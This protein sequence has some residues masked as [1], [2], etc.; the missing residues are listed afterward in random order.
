MRPDYLVYRKATQVAGIGLLLQLAITLSLLIFGLVFTDTP[1]VFAS[2]YTAAGLLVWIS[3]IVVF[4]QH[5][6]ERLEALEDD[7]AGRADVTES[8][9]ASEAGETNVAARRLKLMHKWAMPIVS[10]ALGLIAAYLAWWMLSFFKATRL[11]DESATDFLL[12][13]HRGWAIA[14]CLSAALVSFIFSR[15][16]AGMA[17]IP[18]WQNLRGGASYMAGNAI[19]TL[20]LAI[21]I[22]FRFFDNDA[23]IETIARALPY[24]LFVIALEIA[25]NFV[26]NLYRPRIAGEV[27]RPAFD[28]R[29][30]SR[31]ATPDSIIRSFNEAVNYQFGFDIA[32]SWGYQ[33]LLRSVGWLLLIGVAALVLLNT[34]VIV[35]PHQQG[36]RLRAGEIVGGR[37]YESGILWK[38]PW[39]FETAELYDVGRVRQISLTG[40]QLQIPEVSIWTNDL[41][42]DV[43]LE[44]F[45]VSS[46]RVTAAGMSGFA[47]LMEMVSDVAAPAVERVDGASAADGAAVDEAPLPAEAVDPFSTGLALV[48]AE[49]VMQYRIRDENSG[50]IEYLNFAPDTVQR[51]QSLSQRERA[52]RMLALREISQYLLQVSF[53]EVMATRRADVSVVMRDRVQQALDSKSAGIEVVSIDLVTVRPAGESPDDYEDIAFAIQEG[54]RREQEARQ[55]VTMSLAAQAGDAAR[56][57]AL[58]R[59]I[60]TFR[61]LE[62][63]KGRDD[64]ETIEQRTKVDEMFAAA[65][66]MAAQ[67]LLEAEADRWTEQM[68]A[69][70]QAHR[71]RGEAMPYLA[72]PELYRQRRVMEVLAA[73]LG[74]KRKYILSIDPARLQIDFDVTQL[75]DMFNFAEMMEGDQGSSQ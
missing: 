34:M 5:G 26:L 51:R 46:P 3:L 38:W 32:S 10:I 59:E 33:L 15:F 17:K 44:P 7:E 40:R 24:F 45:I 39:P 30:L 69:R 36:V 65:G 19:V 52:I 25:F 70:G 72:A 29:I 11:P 21:G 4:H 27:P 63:T 41:R 35:E 67:M 16:V 74:G 68:D 73:A 14:I 43:P 61:D 71:V 66:G 62:R 57:D 55:R 47:P 20:A 13:P 2:L 49:V 22:I 23:V 58:I 1:M 42:T 6:L 50:L 60:T 12:T 9:F 54:M 18:A 56:A 48:T 28:S 31:V 37:V 53:D 75:S 8:V 64:P